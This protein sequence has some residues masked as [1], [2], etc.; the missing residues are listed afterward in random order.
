MI[1]TLTIGDRVAF[2]RRRRGQSQEVLAGLVGRT[3]DWL[4]SVENNKIE[5]DRLLVIRRLADALDASSATWSPSPRCS[6]GPPTAGPALCP[7]CA[8]C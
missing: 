3:E 1:E 2:Y 4:S 8:R 6:T 5:L 7:S